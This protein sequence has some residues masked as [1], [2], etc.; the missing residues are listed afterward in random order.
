MKHSEAKQGRVFIIRLE[1]G[2]ILHE[3]I[4]NFARA[5]SIKAA[6]LTV[7]GGADTGSKL[8]VGP[9]EGRVVPV[10]PQEH[11]LNGV[12]EIVGSGTIFPDKNDN[13]VLHMHIACGR[14]A[15][16]ITGCIRRGV[17]VWH[18]MEIIL[19]ELVGTKAKRVLEEDTGFELLQPV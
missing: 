4:E 16:S 6:S 15:D 10:V 8:I 9:E 5:K 18:V 3:S 7:F 12:H 14:N 13:P 1:D 19:T 2:D 17:K 11:T